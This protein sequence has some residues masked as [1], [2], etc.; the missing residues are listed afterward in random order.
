[1]NSYSGVY[2][3]VPLRLISNAMPAAPTQPR[4]GTTAWASPPPPSISNRLLAV[5]CLSMLF[6]FGMLVIVGNTVLR[7]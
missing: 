2:N 3:M 1:M 5:L 7:S 4:F 6:G